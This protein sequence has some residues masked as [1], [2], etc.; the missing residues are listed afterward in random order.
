MFA[1]VVVLPVLRPNDQHGNVARQQLVAGGRQ[2][3]SGRHQHHPSR[4][5]LSSIASGLLAATLQQ[6]EVI[7]SGRRAVLERVEVRL[8]A[9]NVTEIVKINRGLVALDGFNVMDGKV[10]GMIGPRKSPHGPHKADKAPSLC[11]RPTALGR[12]L[13]FSLGLH[14]G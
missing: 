14:D 6:R 9:G 3:S 11:A 4:G 12:R 13:S 1:L 10:K 8:A 7:L 2:G 5:T